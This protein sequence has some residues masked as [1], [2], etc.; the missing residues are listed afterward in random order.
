MTIWA[1]VEK[2]RTNY[3]SSWK[4]INSGV[5]RESLR[6]WTNFIAKLVDIFVKKER[7]VGTWEE[8]GASWAKG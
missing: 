7:K 8:N 1:N 4:R 2:E 6:F 5:V 3:R